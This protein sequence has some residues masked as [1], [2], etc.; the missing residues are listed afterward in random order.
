MDNNPKRRTF[1]QTIGGVPLVGMPGPAASGRWWE[2]A[3]ATTPVFIR[4]RPGKD[5]VFPLAPASAASKRLDEMRAA[6]VTAIE[7]YAP[8]EGGN[9]FLGLDTINRYRFEPRAGTMDDFRH[10]VRLVHDKGMRIV[11]IDNF[12]Y[13]SVEAVDFLKAC[14]DLRAGRDTREV[15]FYLWSDTADAPPPGPAFKDRYFMVR[16]VHLP[17]YNPEKA[18]KQEFWQYSERAG[19]YYWTKWE[20]VDLAGK[21]VRL[22]Q[23]NW[24]STAFQDEAA[25]IVRYWMDTGIDG[26]LID[27]V[28]WYAGCNW[29]VNR[30]CMTDVIGSYGPKF[31]QPEGAGA[32]RDDPVSWVTEGGWTCIQDYG[33]AIYWEKG[34]NVVTNAIESGDPRP[35][36]AALRNYH[37][38]V[39]EVGGTLYFNPPKFADARKSHLAMALACAAGELIVLAAVIDDLWSPVFPDAEESRILKLKGAHP[40]MHNPGRRQSLPMGA[41]DK[42]Y[43]VLREAHDRSERVIVVMNFQ[44][45]EQTVQ[46]DLSG[47]DFDEMTDLENSERAARQTVW[48]LTLPPYGYRFFQLNRPA[49]RRA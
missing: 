40:A 11:S 16:P 41:A 15:R 23:Y 44:P 27:A 14:D 49:T 9:S 8:A 26:M 28:N 43:A 30:K 18:S 38:R 32:F 4:D 22:P 3:A 33:L 21:R 47:V 10:L 31:S 19:K 36:E 13:S 6:G 25:K 42:H 39:M 34:S 7:V 17:G 46:V 35:I 45:Q 48:R 12:G 5:A 2:T 37:D 20:G 24:G 1:L 29:G